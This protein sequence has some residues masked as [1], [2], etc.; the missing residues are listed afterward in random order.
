MPK[1]PKEMGE[2][3]ARNLPAKTGRTF[4]QWVEL[5][6]SQPH[7]ARKDRIAWLK[8]QHGLGTVTATFIA[9]EAEGKSIVDTYADEAALLNGMFAG[10]KAGL[11]PLYDEL[12]GVARKLGKDVD[13]TVCKTYVGIRRGK[14]FAMIKPTTEPHTIA[15]RTLPDGRGSEA[16]HTAAFRR[17]RRGSCGGGGSTPTAVLRCSTAAAS[18]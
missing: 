2:A 18:L 3:I 1:S 15:P 13:L 6:K 7:A 16:I 5:A 8:S 9:A 10:E 11:R 14:Q 4:E 12:A 17:G